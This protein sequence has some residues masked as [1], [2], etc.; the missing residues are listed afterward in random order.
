MIVTSISCSGTCLIFS[1]PRQPKVERPPRAALGRGGRGPAGERGGA[2]TLAARRGGRGV[3]RWSR[4]AAHAARPRL[5]S[6]SAV[7]PVS[8]RKTSSRLGWPSEKLGERRCRRA[9]ARRP[10]RAARS[11]SPTGADS[12]AGSASGVTA[13][14]SAS[15]EQRAR[16]RRA[17]PGRAGARAA[18][19]ARPTPSAAPAC[20]R[21][22]RL[23]R[24]ITAIR[25]ASWSASSRYCVQSR[26]VVPWPASARTMS[27]TW[28]RERG[29]S[30]VVGSSR[31]SSSGVTTMLAGD[32]EPPAHAAGVVLD[33]PA[34][35][36]G[37]AERVEQLVGAR[38]ACGRAVAEQAPEQ[39]QVL[40]SGQLLVDRRE[41]AGQADAPAH[42]VRLRDDVVAQHARAAA[43]GTQQR[44][45]HR[46]SSSSCR[47]RS[48]RGR[49]RRRRARPRGRRRRRRA[50]RRSA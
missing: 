33:Q 14:P 16:P 43:V 42:R 30:P 2:A 20:P 15:R 29:S 48:G 45:E 38:F 19:P 24:S 23:P 44:G 37:E 9:P 3:R 12:A 46:G 39:D 7:W 50:C 27:Q 35:R 40:A 22:S 11:A 49:R 32:V 26:I 10:P 8:A 13:A 17:A 6:S 1:I 31:N 36:V 28:L 47:R 5:R 34:G 18:S 25:P 21:R 41:L 4:A